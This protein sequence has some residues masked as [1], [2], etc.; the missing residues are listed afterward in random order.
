MEEVAYLQEFE[1]VV[2]N[3]AVYKGRVQRFE[4]CVVDILEDKAGGL[5][6]RITHHV[7]QLYDIG[8]AAQV[9][10]DFDLSLDLQATRMK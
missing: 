5:R 1:D 2:P 4:V 6:L 9:L 3:V 8:T 10:Q 7:Q